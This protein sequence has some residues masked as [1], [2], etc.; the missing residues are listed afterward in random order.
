MPRFL[1]FEPFEKSVSRFAVGEKASPGLQ[2]SDE[3]EPRFFFAAFGVQYS[4]RRA[5]P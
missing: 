4:E 3:S 2:S 5:F 1:P